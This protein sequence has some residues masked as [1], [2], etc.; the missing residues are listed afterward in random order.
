[1]QIPEKLAAA[2]AAADEAYLVGLCNKGTVNR[3][4]KDLA[5]LTD[6]Q[7][8]TEGEAVEVRMGEV[9]CLI[10][11]PLGESRCSCP[12]GGICRHRI[13]A[14][15]WLQQQEGTA[16]PAEEAAP[17]APDFSELRAYPAEKLLRQLGRRRLAATL[18]RFQSGQ[19]AAI[20]ETSVV[21]VEMPWL[22]ATVRLLE[23]I[24]HSTCSCHSRTFCVHKAEALLLWQLQKGIVD[25]SA[26]EE[27]AA[28]EE[29]MDIEKVRGVCQGVRQALTSQLATGLSRLPTAVCETVERM[30]SLCH[31]AQLPDLERALRGLHGAYAAYFARSAACRDTELL[32]RLS[33]AF[34]LASALEEAD[35]ETLRTLAGTF[36]EDYVP[37]GNLKLYLLGMR[38]FSGRGGYEGAI[39]YFW[40]R[41]AH[42]FYT[43]SDLRPTFYEGP[44]RRRSAAAPWG[45]PCPLRQAWNR[46][47]DL[48]GAKA[49]RTGGLSST[50][51]CTAALLA[52]QPPGAVFPEEEM[53]TDFSRL[54]EE[55]SAPHAPEI[56]RLAVVRPARCR[57]QDYDTVG[58]VF[59]MELLDQEGRDL[60]LT[61]RYR[62][63]E[64]KVVDILEQLARRLQNEEGLRPV[65]FGV[66]YREGDRLKLYPIECFL[67]WEEEQ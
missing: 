32:S 63:E 46:G 15:L 36:R 24:E 1:M 58:Q 9:T 20:T 54:L 21:T 30:A 35:G 18:F 59:S 50:Q 4:K 25:P 33:L 56:S 13:A 11:A 29:E 23:P 26:L 62:K 41:E 38:E 61:V 3:A 42:R 5:S 65:F 31:T 22:P 27:A 17:E 55:R 44:P 16:A 67:R 51:Q 37:V 47:L 19:G 53:I 64:A 43:F 49:N 39:Y 10:Q 45:L 52:P 2:L 8:K 48:T 66:V 28:P 60:W 14:I 12:S 34:R 7:V 57:A 40:E 6:P